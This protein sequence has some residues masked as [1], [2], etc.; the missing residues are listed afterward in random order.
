MRERPMSEP[1]PTWIN[2]GEHGRYDLDIAQLVLE[3]ADFAKHIVSRAAD[4]L[5]RQTEHRHLTFASAIDD[6]TPDTLGAA[7]GA[8]YLH[9]KQDH[10][11]RYEYEGAFD[12]L[13]GA[14]Q[15]RLPGMIRQENRGTCLDL[16]LLFASCL[17][18]AKLWPILVVT[19]GHALA[20]SWLHPPAADRQS[21]IGLDELHRHL[22]CGTIVAVECTGFVEGVPKR[23][24][25]LG[26]ADA[27][28]AARELLDG[29]S[30]RQFRFALDVRRAWESG[31]SPLPLSRDH[32]GPRPGVPLQAPPL[33]GHY[34]RRPHEE[35]RLE[36]DLLRRDE[37]P[38]VVVSAVFGL[39]GIGKSTLA[40]AVVQSRRVQERFA[41]GVLWVTLGQNP[42]LLSLLGQWIRD[43]GDHDFRAVD[44][45][46]AS[47]R[48]RQLLQ[49]RAV[50][51]VVDDAWQSEHVEPFR[52]GG[53]RCRLLVTTRRAAIADDLGAIR[54]ELDVLEPEQAVELL[55]ARLDRT[56][57]DEERPQALRLAEAVGRLPL[58]LELAGVRLGRDVSWD[59]LLEALE[60]E[61]AALEALEDPGRRRQGKTRLL[62][63][64]N[65]SLRALHAEDKE[66]WRCFAWLGV[67][68]DD[69]AL[70]APMAAPLWN[71]TE[72]EVE[73]LLE[74][75]W[76]EA[77]LQPAAAVR[78]SGKEWRAY[79]IHDLLH[80]C[81]RRLLVAPE[82]PK[83]E[84]ELPGLGLT[85]AE[86][87]GQFLKRYRE[88]TQGG[89]WHTLAVDGYIHSRLGWHLE[90]A[91][92]IEGL[93]ALLREQTAEGRNGWYEASE[94]LGQ[95]AAFADAVAQ[96]WRLAEEALRRGGPTPTLGLLCRYALV[97][98][99]LNSLAGN[100]P[101]VLLEALVRE[102]LWTVDQALAYAR[103]PPDAVQKVEAFAALVPLLS[104]G[105]RAAVL[106]E[107]LSAACTI[108]N[109]WDRSGALA[110]LMPHL[111]T[112]LLAEALKAARAIGDE[113]A[114]ASALV[115]LLPQLPEIEREAV[116]GEALA[117]A[118][119][120]KDARARARVL[121]A[122]GP[123][124]PVTQRAAV[125]AEAL[126]VARTTGNEWARSGIL[127][128]MAPHLP[129]GLQAEALNDARDLADAGA[130]ARALAALG[131][132]LPQAQRA[133]I[134]AKALAAVQEVGSRRYCSAALQA[135][136]PH[137]PAALLSEALTAAHDIK[138]AGDRFAVL[139]A[140]ASGSPET[141]RAAVLTAALSDA[142]RI[143]SK[144]G[145]SEALAAL[146]PH[147]PVDQRAAVMAEALNDAR[148][149]M[150]ARPRFDA[151][152]AIMAQLPEQDRSGMLPD[153]LSAACAIPGEGPRSDALA[154][155]AAQL[156]EQGRPAVLAEALS[157]ARE[158]EVLRGRMG[159]LPMALVAADCIQD[160]Y[161][162]WWVL[163]S[164]EKVLLLPADL[165]DKVLM[166]ARSIGDER[167]RSNSEATHSRG[168][169]TKILTA[170]GAIWNR[171]PRSRAPG[172]RTATPLAKTR[173][174]ALAKAITLAGE[175]GGMHRLLTSESPDI[176]V[177][178]SE[179]PSIRIAADKSNTSRSMALAALASLLPEQERPPVMA[180]ALA[181][182]RA[183]QD[184]EVRFG[185]LAALTPHLPESERA[186]VQAEAL[187][188]A[189][190]FRDA[191]AR[192]GALA[193]LAQQMAEQGRPAVLAEALSAARDIRVKWERSQA[194]AAL[195]PQLSEQARAMVFAEAL[196]AAT[197]NEAYRSLARVTEAPQ[198]AGQE[199]EVL[200]ADALSAACATEYEE[201]RSLA[202]AALAPQLVQLS[203]PPLF[204]LWTGALP[205]LAARIR[206]HLLADL[207]AMIPLLV[208]LAE[209]NAPTEL[210][211]VARAITDVARWWP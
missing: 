55:S 145:R 166:E 151:L 95:P 108:G 148:A 165:L 118:R 208:A 193:V 196:A 205:L 36:D 84:E 140:L 96:G 134:L 12:D 126:S 89:Q 149:I 173:P 62:A 113:G 137:L 98:A 91:G 143:A 147:L 123:H 115:A 192:F 76:G 197:G 105:A 20:A 163:H 26:F 124:L 92:D 11:L 152:A 33:P 120:I 74:C 122:V 188:A 102:G 202:L 32:P 167:A 185:P 63:S 195:A 186:S 79:R 159:L 7:V 109:E 136:A 14:Q 133:I 207:R 100:L 191:G 61:A 183:I 10:R 114:R 203:R 22:S 206:P 71:R 132:H 153:A 129:P 37:G 117:A 171:L 72:K 116:Q 169:V 209:P 54:H 141:Q 2:D 182:A 29:L 17:A 52:A 156:P 131:P 198:A 80:D 49:E 13:T 56:L 48:L 170:A 67:L 162:R 176:R 179:S 175:D 50:L 78:V 47:G 1:L 204:H 127:A 112:G 161:A 42:E 86:A 27:C 158:P 44:L 172:A 34:V 181:A 39:G 103:R 178:T 94:R 201:Y 110:V 194:L 69:T 53:P 189:R 180:E 139:A 93:H 106:A 119:A 30:P 28:Q 104:P 184:A 142:R 90:Q 174:V 82:T 101:P 75:L 40:A 45:R 150:D 160:Q 97:N 19:R 144:W 31:V 138:D 155:L 70:A 43:L 23:Q 46:A 8:L 21:F 87:H 51:L 81:A 128:A 4:E 168:F 135:L 65:L 77:L 88:R 190:A 73:E 68:P 187:D 157:A 59:D 210:R 64:L 18:N 3:G 125:L 99:S 15:V 164:L 35:Q 85:R 58:A 25:K 200:L 6:G 154:A 177:L 83:R 111:T 60:R 41:D 199:R 107:A 24:H 211:E 16:V 38:G 66:A 146:S 57:R 130:R 9:L 5:Y 121:A